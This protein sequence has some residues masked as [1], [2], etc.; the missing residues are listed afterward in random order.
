MDQQILPLKLPVYYGLVLSR[1]SK[2]E[3]IISSRAIWHQD[4]NILA[5]KGTVSFYSANIFFRYKVRLN[6]FKSAVTSSK[7]HNIL[8]FF[9]YMQDQASAHAQS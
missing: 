2:Q 3:L 4:L 8:Y 9:M 7:D 6:I 5:H 1:I